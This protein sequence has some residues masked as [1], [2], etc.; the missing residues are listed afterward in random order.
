MRVAILLFPGT[1]VLDWVGPYEALHRVRGVELL[2]V[3]ETLE[4]MTADSGVMQYKAN[5]TFEDVASADVLIV[6][7]GGPSVHETSGNPVLMDWVRR[8]DATT[9]YTTSTCTGALIVARA[10]LLEG[11]RATT[12]WALKTMLSNAGAKYVP[13]RWVVSDKYWTA[14]GVSA[15]ID[16][17]LALIADIFGDDTAMMTQLRIEYDPHPRFD[18]GSERTAPPRILAAVREESVRSQR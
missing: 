6:P 18:A 10:G 13:E 9:R 17:T 15:G 8:I 3:A 12:H 2:L 11:R 5:Q 14:A 1:T 7:G 4:L 16:M